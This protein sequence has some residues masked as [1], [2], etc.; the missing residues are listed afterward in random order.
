MNV[1]IISL[2]LFLPF[3]STAAAEAGP[4]W[5]LADAIEAA[6]LFAAPGTKRKV[7]LKESKAWTDQLKASG[8]KLGEW[9]YLKAVALSCQGEG[10]PAQQ[11]L[12]DALDGRSSLPL[13]AAQHGVVLTRVGTALLN[14]RLKE[15]S[16]ADLSSIMRTLLEVGTRSPDQLT[17][18]FGRRFAKTDNPALRE[19]RAE[20][21]GMFSAHA[22]LS[23]AEKDVCIGRL[24][25]KGGPSPEVEAS[26]GPERIT[27]RNIDRARFLILGGGGSYRNNQISLERNVEFLHRLQKEK[28][29]DAAGNHILFADGKADGKDLQ[30]VNPD[31]VPEL[32]S[33]LAAI[34]GTTTGLNLSYRSH[35]LDRVSGASTQA[36]IQKYFDGLK[37]EKGE[38]LVINFTGHGG[39]GE[40]D[41]AQN[42]SLY[43]WENKSI[44]VKDFCKM[45]DKLPAEHPVM[46]LMVQCY[47][48]GFANLIFKEGQA[49]KG[50]ADHPRCGF[51]ATVHDRIAAGCTPSINEDEYYEYTSYFMT[52][53]GGRTRTGKTIDLP[54]YDEDGRVC[55]AE[56][57]AYALIESR[58]LDVSIKTSDVLLRKYSRISRD[59]GMVS[60]QSYAVL[61]DR[62][63]S[64]EKAVLEGLSKRTGLSGDRRVEAARVISS[65]LAKRRKAADEEKKKV[66]RELVEK[67]KALSEAV[68]EQWPELGNPWHPRVFEIL[69]REKKA[70]VKVIKD[71]PSYADFIS[72]RAAYKKHQ[73]RFYGYEA[74]WASLQR[75]IR[76]AENVA[77]EANLGRVANKDVQEH[78]KRLV[79]LERGTLE[80]KP[81]ETAQP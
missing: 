6:E 38:Q 20:I 29:F 40:K 45:L 33:L 25:G 41:H 34:L 36:N 70:L 61:L 39:R 43:L 44:R 81:V 18:Q 11:A 66:S 31:K 32:N 5:K 42:T 67:R 37:L 23:R 2:V 62:A 59:P 27:G 48:G 79:E 50:L 21:A 80:A 78:Y 22:G 63:G 74:E 76:T 1:R 19:V 3:L 51:F 73:N 64:C 10:E 26:V 49:D 60:T 28:G 17:R 47:S 46:V 12:A 56:A 8:L 14:A 77:Y 7:S 9:A 65:A 4:E 53:L 68:R 30:M 71:H 15:G 54:D 57:H 16:H 35:H 58:T 69:S 24:Y 52:A 72:G 13:H 55:F 75:F